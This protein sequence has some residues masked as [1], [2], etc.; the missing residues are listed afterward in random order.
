MFRLAGCLSGAWLVLIAITLAA[1]AQQRHSYVADANR[2]YAA[3]FSHPEKA[4][5]TEDS[6]AGYGSCI[7]KEVTFTETHLASL[8]TAMRGIAA[9]DDARY[10]ADHLPTRFKRLDL[11]NQAD[12]AWRLYSKNIC[13]LTAAGFEG[14]SGEG[15][16]AAQCIFD[17]DRTYAK[18]LADAI[19]LHTL[20]E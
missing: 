4:C 3:I 19:A 8:L 20:A 1:S 9:Q 7:G 12:A 18:H 17:M 6:T 2:E 13:A 10:A 14:G 15:N 11:V 16:A 5:A